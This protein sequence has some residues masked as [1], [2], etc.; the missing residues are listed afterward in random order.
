LQDVFMAASSATDVIV[1]AES[2]PGRLLATIELD[3]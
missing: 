3:I 1:S 2:N